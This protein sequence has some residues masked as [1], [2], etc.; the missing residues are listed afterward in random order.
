MEEEAS[1]STTYSRLGSCSN[2]SFRSPLALEMALA[3]SGEVTG[4]ASAAA[5][6]APLSASSSELV[7]D[8]LGTKKGWVRE[9]GNRDQALA[10]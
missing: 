3:S 4:E 9:Q 6:S 10:K 7:T 8:T 2:Q 1:R 5:S